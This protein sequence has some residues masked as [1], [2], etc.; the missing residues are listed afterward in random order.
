MTRTSL[1]GTASVCDQ[2]ELKGPVDNIF[3]LTY[4]YEVHFDCTMA[5]CNGYRIMTPSV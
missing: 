3:A 2:M 1:S 4:Q 5:L